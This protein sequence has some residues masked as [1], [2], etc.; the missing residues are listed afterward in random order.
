MSQPHAKGVG[1]VREIKHQKKKKI[2][3]YHLIEIQ[4]Y[5]NQKKHRLTN[6]MFNR[7]KAFNQT[8]GMQQ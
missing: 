3:N 2:E 5:Q 1:W 6:H 4:C 8:H 7:T